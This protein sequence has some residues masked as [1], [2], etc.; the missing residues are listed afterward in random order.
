MATKKNYTIDD[1]ANRWESPIG[2]WKMP[3]ATAKKTKKSTT[4]K[5]TVKKGK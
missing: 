3:K 1:F 4:K 2:E 5:S